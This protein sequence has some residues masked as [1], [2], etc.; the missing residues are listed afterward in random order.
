VSTRFTK[1]EADLTSHTTNERTAA[2]PEV[3][4]TG[5]RLF[6][7]D[8][9]MKIFKVGPTTL[10]WL[11]CTGKLKPVHVG[12]RVLFNAAE[13]ERLAIHGTTLTGAEKKAAAKHHQEAP[14]TPKKADAGKRGRRQKTA[15]I[16]AAP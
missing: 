2:R 11:Q 15:E 14:P 13:I 7:R 4:E 8:E 9:A 16:T 10:Y 5:P 12:H 1:G 6:T 3:L